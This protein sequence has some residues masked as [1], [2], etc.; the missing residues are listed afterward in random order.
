MYTALFTQRANGT[1]V[2]PI[3]ADTCHCG[4]DDT[5]LQMEYRICL[6]WKCDSLDDRG[7]LLDN[8]AFA[9]YWQSVATSP[10]DISCELLCRKCC[11]DML[12]LGGDRIVSA[13]VEIVPFAGVSVEYSCSVN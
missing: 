9:S 3:V 4:I 7:F 8:L 10:I 5:T 2:L 11:A 12:S 1:A 13:T 6:V